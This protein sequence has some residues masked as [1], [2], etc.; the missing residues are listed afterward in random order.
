MNGGRADGKRCL[1]RTQTLTEG[2][3]ENKDS[4]GNKP[5]V[6]SGELELK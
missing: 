4:L 3:G 5:G 2:Q 1:Q 6:K